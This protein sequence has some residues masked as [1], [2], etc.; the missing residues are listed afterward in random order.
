[1]SRLYCSAGR[2]GSSSGDRCY[3]S[4]KEAPFISVLNLSERTAIGTVELPGGAE[5]ID[6][7]GDGR[8][9]YT[10]TPHQTTP[11]LDNHPQS[12]LVKIDI[13]TLQVVGSA[14]LQRAN[15]AVR[16]GAN[17]LVYVTK[18]TPTGRRFGSVRG[19]LHVIDADEM[20]I[21]D[22]IP[23]DIESFTIREAPDGETVGVANGGS[24]TVSVIDL[25][26]LE[27]ARTLTV[28]PNPDFPFSGTHGL[29]FEF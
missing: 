10:A 26:A 11:A 1:V 16:V 7:S 25:T 13:A 29:S 14:E 20:T 9:L 28:T 6:I 12:R 24:G 3:V 8:Y 21:R 23:L 27:L 5:E 2:P 4:H 18:M 15:S 17:G 22:T 19:A